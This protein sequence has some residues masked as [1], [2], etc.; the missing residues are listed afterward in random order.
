MEQYVNQAMKDLRKAQEYTLYGLKSIPDFAA[1]FLELNVQEQ[2]N[3][4]EEHRALIKRF[5]SLDSDLNSYAQAVEQ[6]KSMI[7]S[8]SIQPDDIS[9]KLQQLYEVEK[10]KELQVTSSTHYCNLERHVN[11]SSSSTEHDSNDTDLAVTNET[12]TYKCPYTGKKMVAPVKNTSCGHSYEKE[13]I[14]AYIKQRKNRAKCP[15]SGCIN[16]SFMTPSCLVP[17]TKL[18]RAMLQRN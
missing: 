4:I 11:A 5:F 14:L 13:A 7:N 18:K 3:P 1:E 16:Q 9:D 17:D 15:V 2:L 10:T 12:Q 8:S 6:V